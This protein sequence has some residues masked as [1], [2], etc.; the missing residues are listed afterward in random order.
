M[1]DIEAGGRELAARLRSMGIPCAEYGGGSL[2]ILWS[3]APE[4]RAQVFEEGGPL[5]V[6]VC[7]IRHVDDDDVYEDLAD[8]VSMDEAV[9]VIR[10][11][12]AKYEED[13]HNCGGLT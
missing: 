9:A 12:L 4:L 6:S 2:A 13:I 5:L 11:V 10:D 3:L 8:A 1:E 7:I